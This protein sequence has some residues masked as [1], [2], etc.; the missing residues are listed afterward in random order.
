MSFYGLCICQL[1]IFNT[2]Q[3]STLIEV[4]IICFVY[5]WKLLNEFNLVNTYINSNWEFYDAWILH[6]NKLNFASIIEC[7]ALWFCSKINSISKLFIFSIY[8][9]DEMCVFVFVL[10]FLSMP[11]LLIS[12]HVK[13]NTSR[14]IDIQWA[15]FIR[16][17]SVIFC[18][19]IDTCSFE[20]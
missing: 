7:S 8:W 3:I 11:S 14:V 1:I 12:F 16:I 20:N 2:V 17:S 10:F 18:F 15:S 5:K 4:R 13:K 6:L 19:I 9:T